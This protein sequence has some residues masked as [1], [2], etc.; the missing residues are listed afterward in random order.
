MA[1]YKNWPAI[2]QLEEKRF[3]Y[4]IATLQDPEILAGLQ[5]GFPHLLSDQ[6]VPLR[7][8]LMVIVNYTYELGFFDQHLGSDEYLWGFERWRP[9][10]EALGIPIAVDWRSPREIPAAI[11]RLHAREDLHQGSSLLMA[12]VRYLV[13]ESEAK[14]YEELRET[15]RSVRQQRGLRRDVFTLHRL[16]L[17]DATYIFDDRDP[18]NID[19]MLVVEAPPHGIS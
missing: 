10:V 13:I 15:E 18:N 8:P 14:P 11:H 19:P 12:G 9:A 17:V 7:V 5:R 4:F 16:A 3:Q 6:P 2:C 1:P